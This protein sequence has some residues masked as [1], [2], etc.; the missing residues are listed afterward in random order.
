ME[1]EK[2]LIEAEDTPN[3]QPTQHQK[4]PL[5]LEQILDLLAEDPYNYE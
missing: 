5:K 1:E 2:E 4:L 3:E